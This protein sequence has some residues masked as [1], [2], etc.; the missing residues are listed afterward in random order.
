MDGGG[1]GS[2]E[3]GWVAEPFGLFTSMRVFLTAVFTE[4]NLKTRLGK[5]FLRW[6]IFSSAPTAVLHDWSPS[7]V[8]SSAKLLPPLSNKNPCEPWE[9]QMLVLKVD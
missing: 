6:K 2:K 3:N 4:K 8:S 7:C 9:V 1:W 5:R